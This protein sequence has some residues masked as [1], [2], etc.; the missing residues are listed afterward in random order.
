[1]CTSIQELII[2]PIW[3]D[4]LI[5]NLTMYLLVWIVCQSFDYAPHLVCWSIIWLRT[6]LMW[7]DAISVPIIWFCTPIWKWFD[8]I[9]C[10]IIWLRPEFDVNL[11]F[12]VCQMFGPVC[13]QASRLLAYRAIALLGY[14]AIGLL[15]YQSVGPLGYCAMRLLGY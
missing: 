14:W 3:Y 1:M 2:Q 10:S 9:C 11:W 12:I 15:G 6:H 5:Q 4:L 8:K 13:Y 7:F